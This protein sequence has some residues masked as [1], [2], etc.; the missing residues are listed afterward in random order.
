MSVL[1]LITIKTE[2]L[3]VETIQRTSIIK[4]YYNI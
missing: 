3:T 4:S 2:G 1:D